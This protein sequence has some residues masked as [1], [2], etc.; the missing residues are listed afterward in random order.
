MRGQSSVGSLREM[1]CQVE[2]APV[3]PEHLSVLQLGGTECSLNP[4]ALGQV[5]NYI[6]QSFH[7]D[8]NGI[9]HAFT[10]PQMLTILFSGNRPGC[11]AAERNRGFKWTV[12]GQV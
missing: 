10:N 7:G 12:R 5:Q 9:Q 4:G 2:P 8:T 11:W 6:I 3:R 1:L